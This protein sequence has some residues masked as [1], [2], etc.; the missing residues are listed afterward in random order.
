MMC[1]V[2][3]D[4]DLAQGGWCSV[5]MV[6]YSHIWDGGRTSIYTYLITNGIA[7]LIVLA[8]WGSGTGGTTSVSML[9]FSLLS[10]YMSYRFALGIVDIRNERRLYRGIVTDISATRIIDLFGGADLRLKIGQRR[11]KLADVALRQLRKG[12]EVVAFHTSGTKTITN[13]YDVADDSDKQQEKPAL[14]R[15][16]PRVRRDRK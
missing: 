8:L 16:R 10:L 3:N 11:F 15:R 1:P 6:S 12:Q 2:C 14:R 5:C 9:S 13:L 7:L 4:K